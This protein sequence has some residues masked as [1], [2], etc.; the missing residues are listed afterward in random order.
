MVKGSESSVW[1]PRTL[2]LTGHGVNIPCPVWGLGIVLFKPPG[3][4]FPSLVEFC[5][6][7]AKCSLQALVPGKYSRGPLW[8]LRGSF[9]AYCLSSWNS[10]NCQLPQPPS[11]PSSRPRKTAMLRP[12]PP[13]PGP[14]VG[15]C[16]LME[17]WRDVRAHGSLLTVTHRCPGSFWWEVNL[18]PINGFCH[19]YDWHKILQQ[20]YSGQCLPGIF[21]SACFSL[22]LPFISCKALHFICL[23]LFDGLCFL[24]G[25]FN[26]FTWL[27]LRMF[28]DLVYQILFW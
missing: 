1:S 3:R 23:I 2:C 9:S 12:G 14:T 16:I 13:S 22:H 24:I 7:L 19:T 27:W 28:L 21:L 20:L 25:E 11:L 4:S 15:H 18:S 8:R 17:S 10:L 26:V 6:V 5:S